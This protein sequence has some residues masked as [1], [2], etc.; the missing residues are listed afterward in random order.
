MVDLTEKQQNILFDL[1]YKGKP[2][3]VERQ[4][5][6]MKDF[7][8]GT[9]K[10]HSIIDSLIEKNNL[11]NV[12]KDP[13]TLADMFGASPNERFPYSGD[14]REAMFSPQT[15]SFESYDE[16][17]PMNI[18]PNIHP[19]LQGEGGFFS[20]NQPL[21]NETIRKVMNYLYGGR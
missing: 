20:P 3:L 5:F 6:G 7:P 14:P 19:I 2:S 21:D 16:R 18:N 17:N 8:S 11:M 12:L 1:I 9:D 13:E 4:M 10:A 15:Q